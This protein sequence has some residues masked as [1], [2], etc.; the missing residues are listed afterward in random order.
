[1]VGTPSVKGADIIAALGG[2]E[3]PFV[4]CWHGTKISTAP[5][6]DHEER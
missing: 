3:K 4:L 5:R 6:P 2:R 1:M